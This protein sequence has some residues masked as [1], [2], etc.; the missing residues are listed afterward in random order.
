MSGAGTG[1]SPRALV[2]LAL[3]A[4]LS[5]AGATLAAGCGATGA[6][7]AAE[8]A[9]GAPAPTAP[10]DPLVAWRVVY[11]VLQH[12]RCVNCHPAGDAPLQ[13]DSQLPHGQLVQ[14]GP[15][16]R[17]LFALRCEN[18]HQ[19]TNLP[20]EHLPPGTPNWHLPHPE[21]PLVFEGRSSAELCRQ[22]QDP[23]RNGHKSLEELYAHM[24][25]DPL[26][27]WGWDPGPG[28]TPIPV[29]HADLLA[30]LRAW[31][32]AGCACPEP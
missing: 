16:G 19:P 11:G 9:A 7:T 13:G 8:P 12:P 14:R 23:A 22:I 6:E 28:R 31:I 32:D 26:V 25:S 1:P 17:G 24:A 15:D 4:A 5:V 2:A 27:L 10:A 21:M 3:C 20:G 18:C 30:A 29:P